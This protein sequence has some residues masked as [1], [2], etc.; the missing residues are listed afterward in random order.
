MI[1]PSNDAP[2]NLPAPAGDVARR[3]AAAG[4]PT[5]DELLAAPTPATDGHPGD[6]LAAGDPTASDTFRSGYEF[7][8]QQA[9]DR[10]TNAQTVAAVGWIAAIAAAVV[11]V[12]GW[13]R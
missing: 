9:G 11:A 2:L 8:W 7:A 1:G 13:L 10:L 3:L 4:L 6:D 12:W 5:T